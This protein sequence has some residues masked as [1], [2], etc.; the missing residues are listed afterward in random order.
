MPKTC[1]YEEG[2]RGA[3]ILRG[4]GEDARVA[5]AVAVG[6]CTSVK[7]EA[8]GAGVAHSDQVHKISEAG[9][10]ALLDK[11]AA[12]RQAA[13]PHGSAQLHNTQSAP[14]EAHSVYCS[15]PPAASVTVSVHTRVPAVKLVPGRGTCVARMT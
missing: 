1:L 6:R 8:G 4:A 7:A 9:V 2:G 11:H 3:E 12:G 14:Q 5:E 10:G 15:P 13:A